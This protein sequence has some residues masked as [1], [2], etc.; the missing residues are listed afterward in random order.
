MSTHPTLSVIVPAYNAEPYLAACLDSILSQS[1]TDFE[2]ILVNDGSKDGSGVVCDTYAAKDSRIRVFHKVNGG[3]SSARNLALKEARGEWVTFVDSDDELLQDALGELA[4]GISDEVDLVMM[5]VVLS[6][7]WKKGTPISREEGKLIRREEAMVSMF[8]CTDRIYEGYSVAKLYRRGLITAHHLAFDPSISIKEDTL[9]I[10]NY[11]CLSDKKV[12]V[13]D[14]P[15]YYYIQRPASAMESLKDSYNP[16][17]LTS[18]EATVRIHRLIESFFQKSRHLRYLSR[19]EVM[20]RV[21]RVLGHMI[22][23]NAVDKDTFSQYKKRAFREVGVIHYLDYQ[24]RRTKRRATRIINK[25]F[26]T[27]FNV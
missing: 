9:F 15:V 11:L 16:K 1:F 14:T 17:Y 22:S 2:V 20:N 25:V 6:M 21:Y 24:F 13:S 4:S 12:F 5:G 8:N 10:V 7:C 3:V 23:H 26:N 18:F 27:H 19:E